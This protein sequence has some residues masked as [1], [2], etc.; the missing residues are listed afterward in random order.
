[1][2]NIRSYYQSNHSGHK[3]IKTKIQSICIQKYIIIKTKLIKLITNT[4]LMIYIWKY[5]QS[6]LL[7]WSYT[8][9][10][11]FLRCHRKTVV[12]KIGGKGG[13]ILL[14]SLSPC[15]YTL[16]PGLLYIY[17]NGFHYNLSLFVLLSIE[18]I[19]ISWLRYS[20]SN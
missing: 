6:G 18:I 9:L 20:L 5:D 13:N 11:R 3:N 8:N 17:F 4:I 2:E 10:M 14:S 1:M 16:F 12:R 15:L 7:G 19:N